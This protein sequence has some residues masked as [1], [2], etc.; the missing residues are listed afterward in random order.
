MVRVIETKYSGRLYV[1]VDVIRDEV[2]I[3]SRDDRFRLT[4]PQAR[5]LWQA[6]LDANV[7]RRCAQ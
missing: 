4:G 7:Q 1:S 3:T 2:V 6:I 5:D